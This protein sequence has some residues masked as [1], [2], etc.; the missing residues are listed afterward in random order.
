MGAGAEGRSVAC[1]KWPWVY[2]KGSLMCPASGSTIKG[3]MHIP[4]PEA[5]PLQSQPLQC[6]HFLTVSPVSFLDRKFSKAPKI[7][8]A[9]SSLA[10]PP[11]PVS[12]TAATGHR[13]ERVGAGIATAAAIC[14]DCF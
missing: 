11:P 4:K 2:K 13:W 14:R 10:C 6:F 9:L 3:G 8:I 1:Y 12:M 7:F 5:S